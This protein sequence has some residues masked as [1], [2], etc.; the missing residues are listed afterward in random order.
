MVKDVV[1]SAAPLPRGWPSTVHG[2]L[3]LKSAVF[4]CGP[5]VE[6]APEACGVGSNPLRFAKPPRQMLYNRHAAFRCL[7]ETWNSPRLDMRS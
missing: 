7:A 3:R 5:G 2:P 4:P 6:I 1:M